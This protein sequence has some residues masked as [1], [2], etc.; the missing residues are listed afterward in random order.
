MATQADDIPN[1]SVAEALERLRQRS[2]ELDKQAVE[3]AARA[4]QL[5]KTEQR[6]AE[7]ERQQQRARQELNRAARQAQQRREARQKERQQDRQALRQRIA[8]I[9]R[10]ESELGRRIT[11]AHHDIQQ[12]RA[13]LEQ[14]RAQLASHSEQLGKHQ[15]TLER[16]RAAADARAAELETLETELQAARSKLDKRQ[17]RL[18][19]ALRRLESDG[20]ELARKQ[21]EYAEQWRQTR[22][23][24]HDLAR[25]TEEIDARRRTLQEQRATLEQ[26]RQRLENYDQQLR[27]RATAL[28]TEAQRLA[29]CE[30]DLDERRKAADA[31]FG[32]A[33]RTVHAAEQQAADAAALRE[34]AE[35]RDAETRQTLLSLE[36]EQEQLETEQAALARTQEELAGQRAQRAAE[37]D[38][39]RAKLAVRAEEVRQAERSLLAGPRRWWL[40]SGALAVLAGVLAAAAWL[41]WQRPVY[42]AASELK[43]A[44]EPAAPDT[45]IAIHQRRLGTPDV[46]A[47]VLDDAAL[48]EAWHAARAAGRCSIIAATDRPAIEVSVDGADP[49]LLEQLVTQVCR[50]Y[51]ELVRSASGATEVESSLP[52]EYGPLESELR[53][54]RQQHD[55]HGALLET[56]AQPAQRDEARSAVHR[57]RADFDQL[58]KSLD[59]E[60]AQ[61]DALVSGPVTRGTVAPDEYERTL[62][63]D[64]MYREDVREFRAAA[65]AY[66]REL[67]VALLLVVDQACPL[68]QTLDEFAGVL[69]E[70][71]KLQPPPATAAVLE[72]SAQEVAAFGKRL[73]AF[74]QE[75]Q[76]RVETL[77][78]LNVEQDVVELVKQQTA[79]ADGARKLGADSQALAAGLRARLDKLAG[80]SSGGTREVVVAAAL[81]GK[82]GKLTPA[83][84][85]LVDAAENTNLAG[86]F[87][88]DA[89]DRQVRGL[90]GRLNR[91]QDA[92]RQQLQTAADERARREH[93]AL[94]AARRR[95]VHQLEQQREELVGRLSTGL[96]ELRRLDG[97]V[98]RR[99]ETEGI[100][101]QHN[102][103]I[104]EL[105]QKIKALE[106]Q[107]VAQ[108]AEFAAIRLEVGKVRVELIAGGQRRRDA[109]LAGAGAFVATF[110]ICLLMIV[111]SPGRR[112][113]RWDEAVM[114]LSTPANEPPAAPDE[115]AA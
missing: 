61:L 105:E 72:E 47:Q 41:N 8:V 66:R 55:E 49:E 12:Q 92:L 57:L 63:T 100:V 68:Q 2:A 31:L 77:K 59:A 24:R 79:A 20:Q 21:Q 35:A 11:R 62:N 34:Q 22:Q 16:D 96:D 58:G 48:A 114:E 10:H 40:R 103:A 82:L 19:T 112:T 37:L 9:H 115:P 44:G 111:R 107:Q 80:E 7:R 39:F 45:L 43:I 88:L 84:N 50:G 30:A 33:E 83:A 26:R 108:L 1:S 93:Q 52:A 86:N 87:R 36:L 4:G 106:Q 75:C 64:E 73:A 13:E 94:I 60:R 29:D 38:V 97:E 76:A 18:K 89:H 74:A 14:T 46:I 3:L 28:D 91:R 54:R 27:G 32:Q 53:R 99:T 51:G 42:R 102:A 110:T 90:R 71:R 104:A 113:A 65:T 15:Q 81:R 56:L 95:T 109:A 25:Q 23:E 6:F 5:S 69:A 85:A 70:Q 17:T 78:R 67:T 98:V 101:R